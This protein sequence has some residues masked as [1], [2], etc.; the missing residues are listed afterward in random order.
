M[1][2]PQAD[3]TQLQQIISG[4]P[5]GVL[6]INPDQTIAWSNEA[7]LTMHGVKSLKE[8]GST[9]SEYRERFELRYRN[10]HKLPPGEY[11]MDRVLAGE[12]F[13][14]VVVEVTRPGEKRHR[15][16]QI[17]SM[18]VTDPEG[19]PDCLVL[20]LE[21]ETERFDAENRFERA[22][23]ANP[24]PAIITRLSDCRY[25]KVNQGFMEMTGFVKE[26]LIGRSMHEYDLLEGAEKRNLAVERLHAGTTIPQMEA[27]LRI[28][29]GDRKTV[30]MAGQPIEIGDE[31]C[32]LFTF[33]DLHPRKQAEDALKQSEQRFAV[34]F[35]M[36]PGPMAIIALDGLRLLD[37]NDAFTAAIGWRREEVIGR[38]EPDIGLWGTGALRE[39]LERQVK[40]TGH[41]RSVDVQI[42]TKDGRT[43]DYLLSAETVTIHGE[44]CVL[45][46]MLDIT[47]RKQT[48]AELLTAIEAVM[49]DTSWF[50]QKIVEK[51]ASLTGRGRTKPTGPAVSDV[52]PRGRDVL[53][54]IAQGIRDE[55]I[56]KRLGMSRNTV[57]NHVSAIY[58]LTGMRRRS[59]LVIWAPRTRSG[60][61][62]ESSE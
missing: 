38:T 20:V 32:M 28:A 41:L 7:A 58:K 23:N 53:G 27:S 15:V 14:E 61:T 16:Q 47:E 12:A 49:Q 18:V 1:P 35:R 44:H 25:V 57:K 55:D 51:L 8:L 52:T 54:L 40:Q 50:G 10:Q 46:V 43:C 31:A 42:E 60:R 11:P 9:V 13:T 48:E 5:E 21:D 26:A 3:R 62:G 37:V 22:F 34:A 33:A 19:K 2:R 59:E 56:S 6:I 45:T 30:I 4:L 39:E 36:A 17:R 24:A 29:S